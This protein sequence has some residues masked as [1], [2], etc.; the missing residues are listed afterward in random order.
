MFVVAFVNGLFTLLPINKG[1]QHMG[2]R[3][4]VIF[5]HNDGSHT[6]A[7]Y[8]HWCGHDMPELLVDA[9]RAGELRP[10]DA[11]Y[12]AAR[13]CGWLCKTH[14]GC[15]G[16][17]LINAPNNLEA[18]TLKEFSHGDAGVLVVDADTGKVETFGGYTEPFAIEGW[19]TQ[20]AA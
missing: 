4:L 11:G 1:S 14:P 16:V 17:G 8:G 13:L 6:P 15:T 18:E 7:V 2:D 9:F 20:A 10:G 19:S 3:V 5:K 12:S